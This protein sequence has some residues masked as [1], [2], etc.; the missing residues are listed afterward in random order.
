[1]IK[2]AI[3]GIFQ[4]WK[5]NLTLVGCL[6]SSFLVLAIFLLI[7]LNLQNITEKLKGEAQIE[8]Y[9]L[10]GITPEQI[11]LLRSTIQG[12]PEVEKVIFKS[13]EEAATQMEDYLGKEILKGLD[14]NPLPAS[15]QVSLREEQRKFPIISR[16]SSEIQNLDGVEEVEFGREWL[17]KL[18]NAWSVFLTVDWI[19]G[20][21]VTLS[22]VLIVSNFIRVTVLSQTESIRVMKL[23]GASWKDIHLPLLL[24][25]M[26]LSGLGGLLGLLLT[27]GGYALFPIKSASLTFLS[28]HMM[29]GLVLGGMILG[30]GSSLW[31]IKK[32]V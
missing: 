22:V 20:I 1:M 32:L 28:F 9:L 12:Y 26:I 30:G 31:S 4:R 27:R 18:D 21:L 24:Q 3:Y 16:V 29:L 13:K 6:A 23:L 2:Q 14:S 10:D 15:F 7:T 19:F 25:G 5:A 8:V 17:S 11:V